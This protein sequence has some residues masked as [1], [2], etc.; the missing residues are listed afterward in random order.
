VS[1][2]ETKS[3]VRHRDGMR[4]TECGITNEAHVALHGRSLEVH[5]VSPGSAYTLDG[6]VTLCRACHNPKPKSP[7]GVFGTGLPV[8]RELLV[9]VKAVVRATGQSPADYIAGLLAPAVET[10]LANLPPQPPRP[11]RLPRN[12]DTQLRRDVRVHFACR[13]IELRQSVGL[14]QVQLAEQSGVKQSAISLL[15]RG[16]RT[17]R[18]TT[19]IAFARFF[20]VSCSVFRPPSRPVPGKRPRAKE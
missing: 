19:V 17:P 2:A 13:L 18:W 1:A 9:K 7:H 6:C 12:R 11:H 14:N 5:R 8:A 3:T 4:C 16:V 20:K 10:D 15:E